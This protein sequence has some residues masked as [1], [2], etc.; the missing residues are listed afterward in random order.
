MQEQGNLPNLVRQNIE[1]CPK[2]WGR[3]SGGQHPR[4]CYR[5]ASH[6]GLCVWGC[7]NDKNMSSTK[8]SWVKASLCLAAKHHSLAHTWHMTPAKYTDNTAVPNRPLFFFGGVWGQQPP[9]QEI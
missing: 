3:G 9:P 4:K 7:N 2:V 1:Q 8:S 5:Q 6:M